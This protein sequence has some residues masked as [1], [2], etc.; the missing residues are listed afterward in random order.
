MKP[1]ISLILVLFILSGC[2]KSIKPQQMLEDVKELSSDKYQGRKTGTE[3]NKLASA[4]ILKRFSQI[5]IRK[6]NGDYKKAFTFKDQSGNVLNGTNL[7]GFI[8]GKKQDALVISAHYD[9]IGVINGEIYNGADD[10]ASGIGGL[11]AIA[12]YFSKNPPEHTLVFA[13]FDAEESGLEGA[14]A[15]LAKPTIDIDCIRLNVNMDMISRNDKNELYV[16]GTSYN[17]Y[18]KESV[19][20]SNSKIK[21]LFGHDD[22]KLGGDD[23]TTQSD[24]GAF[25][26][27]KIPFLYFGV[28]DHADYHKPSDDYEKINAVFYQDAIAAI[29][30]VVQNLD[31]NITLRKI[32]R[33]K[34]I[35]K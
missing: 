15:F 16:A 28:Q 27:K 12:Q 26:A 19:I 5:G 8:P 31:K 29:L 17:T 13:A 4:Y 7:I 3:G 22:P 34:L 18:L 1:K 33:D 2:A 10:N 14:K 32:Y 20:T 25:H 21:L 6:F 24:H 30:E 23:W 35:M 11:L 9:H